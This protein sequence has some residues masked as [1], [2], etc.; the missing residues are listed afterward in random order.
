MDALT[1]DHSVRPLRIHTHTSRTEK[2]PSLAHE[3]KVPWVHLCA[4]IDLALA[5]VAVVFC[6]IDGGGFMCSA[7]HDVGSFDTERDRILIPHK[8]VAAMN[9]IL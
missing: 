6:R 4:G 3:V 5:A 7:E 8:G 2:V 9:L 1:S